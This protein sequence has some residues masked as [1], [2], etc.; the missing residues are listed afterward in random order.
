MFKST[1]RSIAV[2]AAMAVALAACGGQAK[3]APLNEIFTANP[4]GT[5]FNVGAATAVEKVASGIKVTTVGEDANHNPVAAD[6]VYGDFTGSVFAKFESQAAANGWFKVSATKYLSAKNAAHVD[7]I[8]SAY[9]QFHYSTGSV[10]VYDSCVLFQAVKA[11]S[12]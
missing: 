1:I 5:L 7:C 9:T 2:L 11:V 12:N 3:A 8:N 6:T 4:A 10:P